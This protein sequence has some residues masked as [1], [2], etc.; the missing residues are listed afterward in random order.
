[1]QQ[2][3]PTIMATIIANT[4]QPIPN[5][6]SYSKLAEVIVDVRFCEFAR[7]NSKF[8]I[9]IGFIFIF[10]KNCFSKINFILF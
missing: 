8:N 4:P 2:N 5:I 10:I 7:D 1:M 6:P 3:T 9:N